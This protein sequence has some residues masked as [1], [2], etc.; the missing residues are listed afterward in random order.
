[1]PELGKYEI[2]EEIGRGGFST[3]YKA[4]DTMLDREVALK[5]LHPQLLTDQAFVRRFQREARTLARLRHPNIVTVYEVAE[6]G[7]NLYIAME[8]ACG[9]SLATAVAER[10]RIPWEEALTLLEPVCKALDYAHRQ[11]IVHR[12]LKL[13]NILL[14]EEFGP[15]L[16]DFGIARLVGTSSMSLTMTG[17]IVGTP[18]Y[19]APEVWDEGAAEAPADI[20]ALG[21]IVYEMLTGNVLFSGATPMQTMRAH[22]K[23]P[24][25][26]ARWPDGVPDGVESILGKALAREPESRFASAGEMAEALGRVGTREKRS[27]EAKP[28]A[29]AEEKRSLPAIL[30]P[31][32]PF[33]PEMILIPAGEFL[34]GSDPERDKASHSTERPQH[35]LYLPAYYIAKTPVTNEQYL[36]FVQ[37][38]RHGLPDHWEGKLS[39]MGKED[40]P[41]TYVS[42]YDA[43][44]YCRWL[45]KVTGKPYGLPSEAE[46]EKAASW[47]AVAECKRVYPWGDEWDASRCNSDQGDQGGTTRVGLYSP[48]GDSPYGC[49]DM[50]GN[51][52][53]WTRSTRRAYPY[54][55]ADGRENLRVSGVARMLRGS[56]FSTESG[57]MRCACRMGFRPVQKDDSTGFR[58]VVAPG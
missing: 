30:S 23:G 13:S 46:W 5:V 44:N 40:H 58:V 52:L 25:F 45:A 8:L 47:D 38:A 53:E 42:W 29:R 10:G 28:K 17:G 57:G 27:A 43:V 7:G 22:D 3:V 39:L 33:E 55:T 24:Q 54:E 32:K 20:Y 49:A 15:Q 35:T 1:M 31:T 12:D 36:A 4:R 18:A 16:A 37:A 14:D 50:A 26:P 56:S 48:Q 51:V 41:V 21:C 2:I 11:R 34:M 19:I 9:S 6:A